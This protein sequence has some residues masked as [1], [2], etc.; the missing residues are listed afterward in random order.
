VS[1]PYDEAYD[2]RGEPRPHYADVLGALGD[3]C[4]LA[5]EASRR[6]GARG[7]TFGAGSGDVAAF[8]PVPRI[9]TEPEWSEL[10][11]GIAQRLQAL[12]AFAA[13]VYVD[14]RV[15]DA[16]AGAPWTWSTC[17]PAR[18]G[19]RATTA[20]RPSSARRSLDPPPRGVW[21]S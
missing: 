18:T 12:E 21:R 5:A 8:D 10:Q 2:E 19:S 9:L 17:A 13:D 20:R 11:A 1:R 4:A 16:G 15:F 14:S 6:L 3:P 7:V